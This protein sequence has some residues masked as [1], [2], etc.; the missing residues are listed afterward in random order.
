[1]ILAS[2]AFTGGHVAAAD[3]NSTQ[4][5]WRISYFKNYATGYCL[6]AYLAKGGFLGP[7]NSGNFQRFVWD[8]NRGADTTIR[9]LGET[10]GGKKWCLAATGGTVAVQE[11]LTTI[12]QR[13]EVMYEAGSNHPYLRSRHRN[14]C[15]SH[16]P[17]FVELGVLGL[18]ICKDGFNDQRWAVVFVG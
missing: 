11:C 18:Q 16:R 6:D 8:A 9:S 10:T 2:L 12:T 3:T 1:M 4:A 17:P 14:T 15:M 13:W 5:T 7:C